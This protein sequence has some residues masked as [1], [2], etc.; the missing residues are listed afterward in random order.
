MTV[1]RGE[2]E[3]HMAKVIFIGESIIT[4]IANRETV[5]T[6]IIPRSN[7]WVVIPGEKHS[8]LQ[9]HVVQ[10]C[11]DFTVKPPEVRVSLDESRART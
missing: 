6:S 8:H 11:F 1:P 2:R 7:D 10:V 3:R 4:D 5:D 9:Y